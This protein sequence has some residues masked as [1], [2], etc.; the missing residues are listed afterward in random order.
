MIQVSLWQRALVALSLLLACLYALPNWWGRAPA[1]QVR[2]LAGKTLSAKELDEAIKALGAAPSRMVQE[3]GEWVLFFDDVETQLQASSRLS[4]SLE[5]KATIALNLVS[6]TPAWLSAI[7]AQPLPLG[8]DL[9]GGVHFALEVDAKA[10]EKN[11]LAAHLQ[12][13]RRFLRDEKLAWVEA[14]TVPGG[15]LAVFESA[16]EAQKA[17]QKLADPGSLSWEEEPSNAQALLGRI[18]PQAFEN[19]LALAVRQNLA[20]LRRRVDELGVAEPLVAQQGKNRVVVQLP[21][22][23]DSARAKAIIGR[24]ASLQVRLVLAW[25]PP[26]PPPLGA[27]ILWTRENVPLAV[28]RSVILTG[29]RILDAGP[30]RNPQTGEAV[31]HV[32]LDGAGARI[33]HEAT[34]AHVGERLAIVL[35]EREKSEVV[36]APVIREEIPGGRVEISGM[37]SLEEATDVALLL[38]S[39]A[40]AAPMSIVEERT[41]GPSLGEANIRQGVMATALGFVLTVALMT[42]YYRLFGVIASAALLANFVLLLALLSIVGATLTLPGIAGIALTLGMAIDANVLIHERIRE[43][44]RSGKTPAAAIIAG[45]E[46]AWGTIL[47][48]NVTTFIAAIALF[49]FGSGPVRGF[50]V[51]LALGIFTS[52]FSAVLVSR[53]LTGFFYGRA[54]LKRISI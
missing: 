46:R 24:T 52:L 15:I 9:Q 41:L 28:D 49:A 11:L 8:L 38:R 31:V 54:R 21:G 13:T 44:W 50:A 16:S 30:G 42:V 26:S 48:A 25:A 2:P 27:E 14:K 51:T 6:R 22:I 53:T 33:F 35:V 20:T 4:Q 7:G 40:L 17:R 12:E 29:E 32:T 18:T 39:G 19:A 43:E 3:K 34:R 23:Q 47:D 10:V 1:L 36:T 5:D 37:R 45:Y